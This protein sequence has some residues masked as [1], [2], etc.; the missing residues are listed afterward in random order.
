MIEI[1]DKIYAEDFY[2][3]VDQLYDPLGRLIICFG[4]GQILPL[5]VLKT[6]E[7]YNEKIRSHACRSLSHVSPPPS[8]VKTSWKRLIENI[9]YIREKFI[10][11]AVS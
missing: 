10:E 5:S 9:D 3:F 2:D 7:Y 6:C 8:F 1:V 11:V 4:C